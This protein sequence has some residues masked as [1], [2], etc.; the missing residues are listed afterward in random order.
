MPV[1]FPPVTRSNI[2]IREQIARQRIHIISIQPTPAET[3]PWAMEIIQF[4]AP[5]ITPS[6]LP[7]SEIGFG[8]WTTAV[9][10]PTATKHIHIHGN[11]ADLR[12][13]KIQRR[14]HP[15]KY[16]YLWSLARSWYV[17]FSQTADYSTFIYQKYN[18]QKTNARFFQTWNFKEA[19]ISSNQYQST[20]KYAQSFIWQKRAR[21]RVIQMH[22]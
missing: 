9:I 8:Q 12:N 4:M 6:G 2:Y 21:K 1:P 19:A 7:S 20:W 5:S 16:Y 10:D 22:P 14:N 18:T 15:R 11:L 17:L 13:Y 3:D